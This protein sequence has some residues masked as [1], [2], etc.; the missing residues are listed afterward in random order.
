MER[1]PQLLEQVRE[2]RFESERNFTKALS[3]FTLT[4]QLISSTCFKSEETPPKSIWVIKIRRLKYGP[5]ISPTSED[6]TPDTEERQTTES[7]VSVS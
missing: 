7:T 3:H 2:L 1:I 5:A 6:S 4:G